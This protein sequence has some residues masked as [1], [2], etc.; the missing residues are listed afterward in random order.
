[1]IPS[2]SNLQSSL[3]S[4]NE[5]MRENLLGV[6]IVKSNNLQKLEIKYFNKVNDKLTKYGIQSSIAALSFSPFVLI[7]VNLVIVI[8]LLASP[9]GYP[10]NDEIASLTNLAALTAAGLMLLSSIVGEIG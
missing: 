8:I 3:D 2:F 10:I 7:I 9:P 5:K 6:R 4:A 1:M